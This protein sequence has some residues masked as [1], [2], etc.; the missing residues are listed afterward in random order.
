MC[1]YGKT[2]IGNALEQLEQTRAGRAV[3]VILGVGLIIYGTFAVS[4]TP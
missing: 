2:T 3:L 4:G 1:S